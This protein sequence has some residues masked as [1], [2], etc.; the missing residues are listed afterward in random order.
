MYEELLISGILT[1]FKPYEPL[2]GMSFWPPHPQVFEKL[3]YRF[4]RTANVMNEKH[5]R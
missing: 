5:E 1:R 3:N 4:E 2:N